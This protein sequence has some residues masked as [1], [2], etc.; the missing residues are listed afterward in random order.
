MQWNPD[1]LDR[2]I[3]PGISSF[4][5]AEI[6]DLSD[7]F[8]QA[9]YWPVNYFLNGVLRAAWGD[10]HRQVVIGLLRRASHAWNTYRDGSFQMV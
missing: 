5:S 8:P 1:L 3:A 2:N 4:T 6:P 10:R 9:D 7:K